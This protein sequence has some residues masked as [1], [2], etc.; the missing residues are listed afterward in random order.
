M[1][2]AVA[3]FPIAIGGFW[4]ICGT[5]RVTFTEAQVQERINEQF[6]RNFPINMRL[7]NL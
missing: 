7:T 5:Q 3:L 2:A 6:D 4:S 1:G